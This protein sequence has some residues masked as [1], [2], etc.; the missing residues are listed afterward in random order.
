[1][2]NNSLEEI[3]SILEGANTIAIAGH[4]NPD[5]DAIGACLA[6][7][8]SLQK[9]G[10]TPVI[11][12]ENYAAKYDVIPGKEMILEETAYDSL[13]PDVFVALDCG[14]QERLGKA[15]SV[16]ER[17]GISMN[18]DHHPSNRH[19]GMYHYV[20]DKASSTSEIIYR[21]L[22]CGLPLEK[23]IASGLYA[24]LIYD[25]GGFRHTST[26][27]ETMRIAGDLLSYGIPF[28]DIY[29]RFFD[30]R[31][32]SELKI[33]GR[34]LTNAQSYFDGKVVCSTITTQEIA[35]CKG[36]NQELDSVINYLN[37]VEGTAVVCFL[38]EKGEQEVKASF[39]GKEGYDVCALS[40]QFG[41][42]GH[43]KAAGCTINQS[44][45]KAKELVLQKIEKML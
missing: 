38:Y 19:F 45:E 10:K 4:T 17:A 1:M 42:G 43:I 9:I 5:G 23:D 20:D 30:S 28:N 35:D 33:M 15:A 25:T 12:L 37:G 13:S 21:L 26:G 24:G 7:G 40:L 27:V 14:D 34:A 31:S 22:D 11:L 16:F 32:F 8:L 44:I 36:T 3:K 39:R 2:Q 18:L 6:L 41:G 29:F